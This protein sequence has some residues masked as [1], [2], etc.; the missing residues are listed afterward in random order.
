MDI[1]N[2][3]EVTVS[4]VSSAQVRVDASEYPPARFFVVEARDGRGSQLVL[5]FGI[6]AAQDLRTLLDG[7]LPKR[8]Q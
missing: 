6:T 8:A 3:T 5:K 1:P 2:P 7:G 4:H